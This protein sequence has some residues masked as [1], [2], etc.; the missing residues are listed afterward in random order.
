M[1][2]RPGAGLDDACEVCV[3][4]GVV[5][6]AGVADGAEDGAGDIDDPEARLGA[7]VV[8]GVGDGAE[9]EVG[10]GDRLGVEEG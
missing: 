7:G 1:L 5:L 8:T 6:G 3:G 9:V 2:S 4:V 10:A